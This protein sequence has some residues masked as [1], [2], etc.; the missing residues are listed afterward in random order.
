FV[1]LP[2][3][4]PDA[5]IWAWIALTATVPDFFDDATVDATVVAFCEDPPV[6]PMR[7]VALLAAQALGR[8]DRWEPIDHARWIV[9]LSLAPDDGAG[10]HLALA[11]ALAQGL[12]ARP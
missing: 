3:E 11:T 7:E 8:A 5:R 12:A 6:G 9:R 4:D 1:E 2:S 10:F